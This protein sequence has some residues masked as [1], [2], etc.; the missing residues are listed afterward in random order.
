MGTTTIYR[1][2]GLGEVL[3]DLFPDRRRPGG[4]PANVAFHASQLG[5][6]GLVCSR[7]GA[8]P[9]GDELVQYLDGQGIDTRYVQRDEEFPTGTVTV[10]P[11]DQVGKHT[12]KIHENVAWDRLAWG[13][14]L[15]QLAQTT[16]AVCYGT[17]A[18][19]SHT[20]CRTI[21][22]FLG[23]TPE[24]CLRV[25]DMNI[26][27][28]DLDFT[29]LERSLMKATIVKLNSDE[30]KLLSR[31]FQDCPTKEID[32]AKWVIQNYGVKLVCVTRG[33]AG[34]LLVS[35]TGEVVES[36][37]N[38]A[39]QVVDTVGSGDAFT[40]ALIYARLQG[41]IL[42]VTAI[43]ANS[44]ASMVTSRAGAMPVLRQEFED[45]IQQYR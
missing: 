1:V 20:T 29:M 33:A 11:G 5:C 12:F 32:L 45:L 44:I 36:P 3:W 6:Y 35:A 34:C 28:N 4:A 42:P 9:G 41:W 39:V 43:F 17:L 16:A 23:A 10:V 38:E 24:S 30:A 40:A 22:R 18:Q 2:V 26:R 19:R 7:V 13:E 25:F 21:H 14:R 15:E 8:D 31:W 27:Q 37:I